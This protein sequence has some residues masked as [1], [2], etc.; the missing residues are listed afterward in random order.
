MG[1]LVVLSAGSR[2]CSKREVIEMGSEEMGG[3]LQF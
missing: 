2:P 1:V 3:V